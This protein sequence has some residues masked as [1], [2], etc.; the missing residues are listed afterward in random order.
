M[1]N[2]GL[3]VVCLSLATLVIPSDGV[4]IDGDAAPFFVVSQIQHTAGNPAVVGSS[5]TGRTAVAPPLNMRTN[6]A[7]PSTLGINSV[8]I[9]TNLPTFYQPTPQPVRSF[10]NTI[11]PS[12]LYSLMAGG[13]RGDGFL[14][15]LNTIE[16][17]SPAEVIDAVENA[18]E[19]RA[20]AI[21]DVIE[22][23]SGAVQNGDDEVEGIYDVFAE[24]DSENPV[25]N[26]DDS[27]GV[28]D[29]FADAMEKKAEALENAAEAAAEYISDQSEEVDDLSEEVLDD[30]SDEN[31]STSS[32]SEVE[33]SDVDLEVDVGID[34]GGDLDLG[35]G[36]DLGG[37]MGM[38][39]A[40][41]MNGGLDMGGRYGR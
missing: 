33:D 32:E 17:S 14:N 37:G 15:Q 26:L 5:Y 20:D 4:H 19:N 35:G 36:V 40:L 38:G 7:V 41:N 16:F 11:D 23:V 9:G 39:G 12:L 34:L 25:E 21:K 29:V 30:D 13:L 24:D 27:D 10:K 3:L 22:T 1:K 2:F 8:N 6:V 18:V 28:Y 31:D